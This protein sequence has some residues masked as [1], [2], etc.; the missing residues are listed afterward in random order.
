[1]N[2]DFDFKAVSILVIVV[3]ISTFSLGYTNMVTKNIIHENQVSKFNEEIIILFE[4]MKDYN[5]LT[6]NGLE[7]NGVENEN[8]AYY[9]VIGS[10]DEVIGYVVVGSAMGYNGEIKVLVAVS[11]DKEKILN[12]SVLSQLETPG[13]GTK[14]VT[15][16]SFLRQFENLALNDVNEGNQVDAITGAT[17]SS[18]AMISA[19]K[20]AVNK[21]N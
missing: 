14:I 13:I 5:I 2:F 9:E 6:F 17:V 20:K 19:V 12:V 15:D 21:I 1:M 16:K 10:K 18:N 8:D 3:V 11:D 4:N 7:G